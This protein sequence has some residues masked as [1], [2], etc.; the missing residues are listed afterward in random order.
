MKISSAKEEPLVSI[1]M[2]CFNAE[3][4]LHQALDSILNQTYKNWEL[5]FWDNQSNDSSAKIFKSYNDSRF[6]YFY[7]DQHTLLYEARNR[8]ISKAK[9]EYLAFCDTD[10][11]WHK[12]KLN[13]QMPLFKNNQV[14]AVYGNI[15]LV[16]QK[17]NRKTILWKA[18]LPKG[19]ILSEILK[20][21]TVGILSLIIKKKVLGA[22]KPFDERFHIIGDFDLMIR[23]STK[24]KFDCVQEPV[25]YYRIHKTNTSLM[26]IDRHIKELKIWYSEMLKHPIIS[27][28]NNFIQ[29]NRMI[30]FLEMKK[31]IFKSDFESAKQVLK[32]IPFS[33]K[34]IKFFILIYLLRDFSKKFV[35]F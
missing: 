7:A 2:N 26:N 16:R 11:W 23:L 17:F 1:I 4:F 14:D 6:K 35:D 19:S 33:I 9:G 21:F 10:D 29:I 25:A 20:N 12:E 5:V 22:T 18:K 24:I 3:N 30:Y 31:Y 28:E 32:K 15:Y 8:A 27:K 13:I 34:K